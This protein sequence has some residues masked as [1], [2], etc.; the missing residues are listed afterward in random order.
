MTLAIG[1]GLSREERES[2]LTFTEAGD[3]IEVSTAS[4]VFARKLEK[5]CAAWGVPID[6]RSPWDVRAVLPVK[7]LSLRLPRAQREISDEERARLRVRFA[8]NVTNRK[9]RE[10]ADI[11]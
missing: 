6:Y 2:I 10:T 5:L 7:C 1:D 9:V 4:P 3:T 11:T 8:E